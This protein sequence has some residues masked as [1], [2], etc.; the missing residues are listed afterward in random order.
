MKAWACSLLLAAPLA[1]V[2]HAQLTAQPI[3]H[4]FMAIYTLV[5]VAAALLHLAS[6]NRLRQSR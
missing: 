2:L 6:I 4:I 5:F 1:A 3:D